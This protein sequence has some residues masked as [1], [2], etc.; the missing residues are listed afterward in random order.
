MEYKCWDI[1]VGD[2][3]WIHLPTFDGYRGRAKV[4]D[5]ASSDNKYSIFVEYLD[6]YMY[7]WREDRLWFKTAVSPSEITEIISSND[8]ILKQ[9]FSFIKL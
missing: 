8:T 1:S 2:I 9:D 7:L 3:I 5:K 4:I 6:S